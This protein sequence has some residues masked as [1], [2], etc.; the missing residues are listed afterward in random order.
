[1]EAVQ[2]T[3]KTVKLTTRYYIHPVFHNYAAS[4]KGVTIN[5]KTR[6]ELKPRINCKT[7]Y[8]QVCICDKSLE[9]PK[10]LESI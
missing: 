4:K 10:K 7:G 6:R 3:K 1:M 9:K 8:A 2:L 5:V